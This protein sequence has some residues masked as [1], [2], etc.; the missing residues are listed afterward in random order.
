MY[1]FDEFGEFLFFYFL[2]TSCSCRLRVRFIFGN[3]NVIDYD[4][5]SS[6]GWEWEG[7]GRMCEVIYWVCC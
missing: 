1:L 3:D 5:W 6:L 7:S 4:D 2:V